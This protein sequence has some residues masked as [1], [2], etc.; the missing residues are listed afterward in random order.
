MPIE[1]VDAPPGFGERSVG[2]GP[3][4][5]DGE[6]IAAPNLVAP[7]LVAPN[8]VAP[9]PPRNSKAAGPGGRADDR[10]T[11]SAQ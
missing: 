9:N 4:E 1:L 6:P 8:P 3:H 5:P 2:I 7:N 10:P 11:A